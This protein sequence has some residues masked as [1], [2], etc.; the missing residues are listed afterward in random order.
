MFYVAKCNWSY[1]GFAIATQAIVHVLQSYAD[2]FLFVTIET[3]I[4]QFTILLG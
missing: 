2:I 3:P 1:L 4:D